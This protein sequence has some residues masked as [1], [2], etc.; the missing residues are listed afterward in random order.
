[1]SEE[2][3]PL[4]VVGAAIADDRG[5]VLVTRRSATQSNPLLWEFPG[6]KIE[7]GE[8]PEEALRREIEE[9]LGIV[10]EVGEYIARGESATG[11]G[12]P[13]WL[14]VYWARMVEPGAPITLTEHAEARW[15]EPAEF[16]ALSWPEADLPAV[17]KIVQSTAL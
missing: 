2:L 8:S 17:A 4:H 14:D 5:R 6:G 13:L 3:P 15:C 1:M 12:R 7:R 16:E 10:I 9:E 11:S